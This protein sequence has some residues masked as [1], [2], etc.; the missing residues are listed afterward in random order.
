MLRWLNDNIYF[1]LGVFMAFA[2]R[3]DQGVEV[4]QID[5]Q[6]G[7]VTLELRLIEAP[8][9]PPPAP[10]EPGLVDKVQDVALG[11]MLPLAGA[12]MHVATTMAS[13][14]IGVD[15]NSLGIG[16]AAVSAA[17]FCGS[18]KIRNATVKGV[19]ATISLSLNC[20]RGVGYIAGWVSTK[21]PLLTGAVITGA[22]VHG[23]HEHGM[24]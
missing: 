1:K 11:L 6:G 2:I 14:A 20:L 3:H 13:E 12:G 21:A 8:P 5:H 7:V 23:M 10:V 17:A 22:A 24:I 4:R 9:P 15:V 16:V 18:A 19:G